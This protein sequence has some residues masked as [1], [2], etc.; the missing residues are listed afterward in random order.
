MF[1]FAC[2]SPSAFREPPR[3]FGNIP[4][5]TGRDEDGGGAT[6]VF[7]GSIQFPEISGFP[8][9]SASSSFP[10]ER[11]PCNGFLP[12]PSLSPEKRLTGK[13]GSG[14]KVVPCEGWKG[15][16]GKTGIDTLNT[17]PPPSPPTPTSSQDPIL[18]SGHR[19]LC[20]SLSLG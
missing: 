9:G 12:P 8:L 13:K 17:P 6:E 10:D 3:P 14:G 18:R 7:L 1:T 2:L 16:L 19:E 11:L 20:S 4:V 15:S 5:Q